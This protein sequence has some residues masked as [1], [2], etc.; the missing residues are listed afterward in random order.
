MLWMVAGKFTIAKGQLFDLPSLGDEDGVA[1][2]LVAIV[3]PSA[4]ETLVFFDDSRYS[5]SDEDSIA[6]FQ[7]H[8]SESVLKAANPALLMLTDRR[9]TTGELM[10]LTLVAKNSGVQ[11]LL[12]AER[13]VE[14]PTE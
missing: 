8:L 9:V 11:K 2:D 14:K 10:R 1:T 4:R 5:L 12:L 6:K 7:V 3:F 13:K